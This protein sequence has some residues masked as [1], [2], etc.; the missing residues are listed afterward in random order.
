MFKIKELSDIERMPDGSLPRMTPRQR[1]QANTLI[2]RV[3]SYYDDGNCL[4]LDRGEEVVCPQSISY[5]VC[6]KFF[7]HIV[8]EDKESK[9]LKASLFQKDVLRRCAVCG[10]VFSSTS[11]NAKYCDSCKGGV[12]RK[13]KAVHAR[14]RRSGV[15]K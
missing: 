4:Y 10:K 13:Q 12:Q 1:Q 2:R 11:N 9:T 5:S 6:C 14:K 7:R 15:E 8:L 3:C